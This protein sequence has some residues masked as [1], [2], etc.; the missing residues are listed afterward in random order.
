MH[1]ANFTVGISNKVRQL[2]HVRELVQRDEFIP[3][4]HAGGESAG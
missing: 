4:A 2:E 3:L 1:H